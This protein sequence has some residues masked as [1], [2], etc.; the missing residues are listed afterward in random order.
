VYLIE[1]PNFIDRNFDSPLGLLSLARESS[2]K[3][4]GHVEIAESGATPE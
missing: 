4:L 1:M 2:G 3:K